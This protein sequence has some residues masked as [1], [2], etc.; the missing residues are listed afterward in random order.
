M[1]PEAHAMLGILRVYDYDWNGAEREFHRALEL[2]PKSEDVWEFYDY[3]YLVPMRRL[4]EAV[5]A[6]RRA[7]ELDPLRPFLQWRLGYRYYLTRQ[8]ERAIEQC[9]NALE[10]DPHYVAAFAYMG[11]A[12]CLAGRFDEAIRA[13]EALRREGPSNRPSLGMAFL[14]Y[15]NALAG[16]TGEAWEL[17]EQ[18]QEL[19]RKALVPASR[20]AWIY[21][22]LGE[23][24][25]AFDW[26]EKAVE[27]RDG[28]IIHLHVDPCWDALRPHP[29][30]HALLRKMNLEP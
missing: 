3:S 18:L 10:L 2:N 28:F 4:E 15:V 13:L 23:I 21:T 6:S 1:L 29:R 5:T 20:F 26:L 30:Y 16:R 19:A 11:F 22:G 8:W 17:L 12:Y 7:M 24:G 25:Q 9:R 14:G 27:E